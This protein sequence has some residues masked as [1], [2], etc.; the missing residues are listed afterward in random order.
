MNQLP[1]L[2][3]KL[4][5]S[6]ANVQNLPSRQLAETF[7]ADFFNWFFPSESTQNSVERQAA[8]LQKILIELVKPSVNRDSEKARLIADHFFEKLPIIY[9]DLVLDA[10]AF[11]E[12]DPAANS[13]EEI[14]LSY[15]GFYAITVYRV[16]NLLSKF[17]ISILP[18]LFTEIAH[19][20]TGIDIH[21]NATIGRSF[22]ID[23]GTG[24][25]IGATSL[26]GD[27][28]KIYQGVTLGAL[29]VDKSQATQKRHP[30][31]ENDVVIYANTTILGGK[32]VVGHDSVIGGNVFVTNIIPPFSI[33]FAQNQIKVRP[34]SM[35]E[36]LNFVI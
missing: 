22:F 10:E 11:F 18:R 9:N 13:L 19:S 24:V 5:K 2:F 23:H 34:K 16:A 17:E 15:P 20:K 35:E 3:Q 14:Q 1:I 27:N 4:E 8:D 12:S 29:H 7:L 33:V 28:V 30:T 26:I 21:P 31:I 32:T 25:V 36:V 6:Q